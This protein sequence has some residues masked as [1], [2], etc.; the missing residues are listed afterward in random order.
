MRRKERFLRQQGVLALKQQNP[1]YTFTLTNGCL[2]IQ[3]AKT[4]GTSHK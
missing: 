2:H 1:N 4:E 3:K